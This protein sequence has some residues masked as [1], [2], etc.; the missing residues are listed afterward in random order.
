MKEEQREEIFFFSNHFDSIAVSY[1]NISLSSWNQR[2][3]SYMRINDH[4]P[5]FDGCICVYEAFVFY[6]YKYYTDAYTA[7]AK[8]EEEEEEK[9][10]LMACEIRLSLGVEI[11]R[12]K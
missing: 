1:I 2:E 10:S 3:S 5:L 11:N 4:F 8:S 9:E 6:T 7:R 12:Q